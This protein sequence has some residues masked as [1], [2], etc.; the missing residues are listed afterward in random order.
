MVWGS[1]LRHFTPRS[2]GEHELERGLQSGTCSASRRSIS[3]FQSPRSTTSQWSVSSVMSV[4]CCLLSACSSHD[5]KEGRTQRQMRDRASLSLPL[6]SPQAGRYKTQTTQQAVCLLSQGSWGRRGKTA[7]GGTWG[8]G[9]WW[10]KQTGTLERHGSGWGE[11]GS[12][13]RLGP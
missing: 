1:F 5:A 11:G 3:G 12:S 7:P 9:W 4:L 13:P 2:S 8:R 10:C 6:R